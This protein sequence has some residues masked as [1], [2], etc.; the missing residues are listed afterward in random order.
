MAYV[1]DRMISVQTV[2][3]TRKTV[4]PEWKWLTSAPRTI[5][6]HGQSA[7][8]PVQTRLPAW[9]PPIRP[10]KPGILPRKLVLSGRQAGVWPMKGGVP[11]R[12]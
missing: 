11:Q 8:R 7:I 3:H 1:H 12:S 6:N 4:I 5:P 9:P 10:V 2:M